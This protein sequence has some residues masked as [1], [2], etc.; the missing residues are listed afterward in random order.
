MLAM[1]GAAGMEE[2]VLEFLG[3][4]NVLLAFFDR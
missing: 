3:E 2:E 4:G 1:S